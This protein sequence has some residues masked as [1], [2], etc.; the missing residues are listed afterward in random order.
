MYWKKKGWK[1]VRSTHINFKFTFEFLDFIYCCDLILFILLAVSTSWFIPQWLQMLT[2]EVNI[3]F[4]VSS[5]QMTWW[6]IQGIHVRL[7]SGVNI[8]WPFL[9]LYCIQLDYIRSADTKWDKMIYYVIV[10]NDMNSY[11]VSRDL[12]RWNEI[13]FDW[14]K[15]DK[16]ISDIMELYQFGS[17]RS[18]EI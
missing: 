8:Q 15:S 9:G 5:R 1:W 18:D 11:E 7:Y 6:L 13:G 3:T 16:K 4:L 12:L 14:I 17:M 10:S 2:P